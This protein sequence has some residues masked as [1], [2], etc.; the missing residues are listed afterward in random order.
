MALG[1]TSADHRSGKREL[2]PTF[3]YRTA[4]TDMRIIGLENRC[5]G[6]RTLGSNSHPPAKNFG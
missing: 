1:I 2:G 5:T 4:H 3:K 6:N